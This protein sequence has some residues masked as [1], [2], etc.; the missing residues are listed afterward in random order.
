MKFLLGVVFGLV[1][2]VVLPVHG[3][4]FEGGIEYL[5]V[6]AVRL[7]R[8]PVVPLVFFSL[9]S[10]FCVMFDTRRFYKPL[11]VV[12]LFIIGST[13]ALT[14]VG[15]L[16]VLVMPPVRIP[17]S[18]EAAGSV[19]AFQPQS[20]LYALFP[21]SLFDVF[22]NG[23]FLLPFSLFALLLAFA[24]V[25][26]KDHT[27]V[28]VNL[29]NA[30]TRIFTVILRIAE[31]MLTIGMVALSCYWGV[32]FREVMTSGVYNTLLLALTVDLAVAAL[33]LFPL[34]TWLLCRPC[35]PYRVL[36]QAIAPV[37]GAFFSGDS[38]FVLGCTIRHCKEAVGNRTPLAP[39]SA[40]LFSIF[41]RG[42]SALTTVMGFVI[43]LHSYSS[44][45]ISPGTVFWIAA[46]A[47]ALSFLLGGIPAGGSF[48]LLTVLCASYGQG[49]ESGYLLLKGAAPIIGSFA[50]AFDALSCIFGTYVTAVRL[51]MTDSDAV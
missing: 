43:I 25:Q 9:G 23:D 36:Y 24:C 51:R 22:Q 39:V 4:G 5:A 32:L 45:G 35:N 18:V 17:I 15:L 20:L 42:G 33:G 19:L 16:T 8:Y 44:L 47:F 14:L 34:V 48:V 10:S 50:C 1:A 3:P 6:L 26:E 40:T 13:L 11:G 46:M 27:R 37:L 28:V 38:N 30:G 41:C 29:F 49:F 7:G 12:F 2:T 21:Y 31:D